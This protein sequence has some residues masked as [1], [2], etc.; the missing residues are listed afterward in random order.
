[1]R[2]T[3]SIE[4]NYSSQTHTHT[5]RRCV[6]TTT[7]KLVLNAHASGRARRLGNCA[8]TSAC[9]CPIRVWQYTHVHRQRRRRM[10]QN[11]SMC[12]TEAAVADWICIHRRTRCVCVCTIVLLY[13][14][15]SLCICAILWWWYCVHLT[16][17]ILP[18]GACRLL[19]LMRFR[20]HDVGTHAFSDQHK[21]KTSAITSQSIHQTKRHTG[22]RSHALRISSAID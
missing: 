14:I 19:F 7:T 9:I 16:L 15:A 3:W 18:V 17:W 20:A 11:T 4:L 5:R 1:M 10:L 22:P 8:H 6:A 21:K 12:A 2:T 13:T